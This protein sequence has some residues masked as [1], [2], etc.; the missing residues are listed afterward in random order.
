MCSINENWRD[1]FL[2]V[3]QQVWFKTWC[4]WLTDRSLPSSLK[5][6]LLSL[7]M[8]V[9]RLHSWT[10]HPNPIFFCYQSHFVLS[11]TYWLLIVET[12]GSLWICPSQSPSL[13]REAFELPRSWSPAALVWV[14]FVQ[15]LGCHPSIKHS[16]FTGPGSWL[17][18]GLFLIVTG[19]CCMPHSLQLTLFTFC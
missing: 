9:T 14:M 5:S 19:D 8:G 3:S 10:W 1:L 2:A 15:T 12:S 4:S 16:P 13:G 18:C 11:S 6:W 7:T 17:W